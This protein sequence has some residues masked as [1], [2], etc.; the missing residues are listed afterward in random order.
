TDGHGTQHDPRRVHAPDRA[1]S[2][3]DTGARGEDSPGERNRGRARPSA[4]EAAVRLDP[5]RTGRDYLAAA[6]AAVGLRTIASPSASTVTV[7]PSFTSRCSSLSDSGS[8]TSRWMV[9]LSG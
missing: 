3:L 9:R 2:P 8:C 6:V 7:S 4:R 1:H 5:E